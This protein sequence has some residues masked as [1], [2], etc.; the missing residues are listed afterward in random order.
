MK[1]FFNFL[2]SFFKKKSNPDDRWVFKSIFRYKYFH[3][4]V[5]GKKS[6]RWVSQIHRDVEFHIIRNIVTLILNE[7]KIK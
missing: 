5:I 3:K 2:K 6:A 4:H 1:F 7:N